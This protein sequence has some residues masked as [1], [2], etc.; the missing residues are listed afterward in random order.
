MNDK[1]IPP[2]PQPDEPLPAD[3][4]CESSCMIPRDIPVIGEADLRNLAAERAHACFF[5]GHRSIPQADAS[6][7]RELLAQQLEALIYQGFSVFLCGAA[8]GFDLL[9]ASE[10]L[11]LRSTHPAL[12]LIFLIPCRNQAVRWNERER[13][14]YRALVARGQVLLLS[15]TY[16][17]ECMLRRNRLLVENAIFGLTYYNPQKI[18]SGTGMTVRY[19]ENRSIPSINLFG[20]LHDST[21][22]DSTLQGSTLYDSAERD[23]CEPEENPPR[24]TEPEDIP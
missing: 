19:A 5:S 13:S 18:N 22:Y 1:T 20:L 8:R 23:M 17:R 12:R 7:L 15:E 11:R 10:V 14:L 9:A 2:V 3:G 6:P 21:L 4:R 16:Q 24:G